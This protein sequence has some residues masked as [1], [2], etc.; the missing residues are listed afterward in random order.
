MRFTW[1]GLLQQACHNEVSTGRFA[2]A[3]LPQQGFHG[4]MTGEQGCHRRFARA[5]LPDQASKTGTEWVCECM[6]WLEQVLEDRVLYDNRDD[7]ALQRAM[8]AVH[9]AA[10]Q[11]E[12]QVEVLAENGGEM[13]VDAELEMTPEKDTDDVSVDLEGEYMHSDGNDTND[14]CRRTSEDNTDTQ[15]EVQSCKASHPSA[16][17]PP[18]NRRRGR[19]SCR[20]SP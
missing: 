2:T 19:H 12:T 3:G 20:S 7:A 13:Q 15:Q 14:E 1:T 6:Q 8:Q 17:R 10:A 5:G 4:K 9:A 11:A 16:P 18:T